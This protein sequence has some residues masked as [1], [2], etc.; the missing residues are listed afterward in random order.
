VDGVAD[1]AGKPEFTSQFL[2]RIALEVGQRFQHVCA[3]RILR[4]LTEV[5]K[6]RL[7]LGQSRQRIIVNIS[8]MQ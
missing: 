6:N 4:I 1:S 3:E 7:E 5:L 8:R 2:Q